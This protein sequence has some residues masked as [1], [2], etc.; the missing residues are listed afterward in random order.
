[1]DQMASICGEAD[2]LMA[3]LCQ[4]AEFQGTIALPPELAVWGIDSGIRHAVT[5][6]DYGAVRVG[7]FMGYRILADLA[8]L[9]V[10]AGDREGHVRVADPR[11]GGY[12][13][14][15]GAEAFL[16]L[17]HQV[18][19]TLNGATF[20]ARYGGTTDSVTRVDPRSNVC[21]L[22][23]DGTPDLRARAGER[24]GAAAAIGGHCGA[25]P[26]LGRHRAPARR[27][28]VSLARQ[29]LG[30][31]AGIGW[32]RSAGRAGAPT[33][34]EA[35]ASTARRLPAAEAAARSR[36]SATGTREIA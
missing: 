16:E 12:L 32:H 19:G 6:A 25:A 36:F 1:M 9:E 20:L 26:P 23:A 35:K 22:E 2:S 8:G 27:A 34:S 17:E 11:W 15:V 30:V 29:L 24:M 31:R 21:G 5:G 14:N 18:P 3:L 7:A 10:S 28:D 13:A 33:G 4:P